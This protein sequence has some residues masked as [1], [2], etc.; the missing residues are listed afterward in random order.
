M[1][2]DRESR[3]VISLHAS[4]RDYPWPR[5]TCTPANAATWIVCGRW[6]PHR[7]RPGL[8]VMPR[9]GPSAPL[10]GS[11]DFLRT[12]YYLLMIVG[13]S[14]RVI[15]HDHACR[16]PKIQDVFRC[17]SDAL[18]GAMGGRVPSDEALI[19]A[20]LLVLRRVRDAHVELQQISQSSE[21]SSDIKMDGPR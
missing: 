2:S 17:D 5:W 4:F 18:L 11:G 6:C 7:H 20:G 1:R 8:V 10:T 12:L 9:E 16:H 21:R 3:A 19:V 14:L 15:C 13:S